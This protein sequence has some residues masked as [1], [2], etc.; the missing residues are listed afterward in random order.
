MRAGEKEKY[1]VTIGLRGTRVIESML[2]KEGIDSIFDGIKNEEKFIIYY[3]YEGD[4]TLLRTED[5]CFLYSKK[6]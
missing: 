4:K 3:C 6:V 1:L 2:C 5:I